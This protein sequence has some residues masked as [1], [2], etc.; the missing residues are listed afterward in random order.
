MMIYEL[1]IPMLPPVEYS[2]NS[3]VFWALR[4]AAGRIYGQAV[5]YLAISKRNLALLNEETIPVFQNALLEL[6][7]VFSVMRTRDADNLISRFKPGLDALVRAEVLAGDDVKRLS[8][9]P[10][11]VKVDKERAPL[12][13][14]R[15]I[16]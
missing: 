10:V 14:V 6:T 3:R 11:I 7:F 9:G 1:E 8:I 13:I 15:L 16:E 12:T 4:H 5:F 2:S